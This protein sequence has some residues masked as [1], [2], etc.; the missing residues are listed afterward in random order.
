ME[1]ILTSECMWCG[2]RWIKER[3]GQVHGCREEK[4]AKSEAPVQQEGPE[5]IDLMRR[6]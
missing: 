2:V 1:N 4:E 3:I 5:T 6:H